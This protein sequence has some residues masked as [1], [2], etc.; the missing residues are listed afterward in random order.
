[1]A[2]VVYILCA[3]T[4]ILCAVLLFRSYRASRAKLLFWS[5]LCFVGLALNNV[6][7]ILDLYVVSTD[8]FYLRTLVALGRDGDAHLRADLELAMK[9][10]LWGLLAMASAVA[11]LLFLR[12][13]KVTRDRMFLYFSAA[14]LAMTLNWIGLAMIEPNTEASLSG[15]RAATHRV[16]ADPHRHHRQESAR[17]A[18][19]LSSKV[20]LSRADEAARAAGST[21]PPHARPA[22]MTSGFT[23]TRCSCQR[24]RAARHERQRLHRSLL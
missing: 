6:L 13:G 5:S 2:E 12:Y 16:R 20:T 9:E 4:S 1:M 14:F 8:L 24:A 7:L 21:P 10:F 17:V 19:R 18:R 22:P 23:T 11:S 3:A 15:V